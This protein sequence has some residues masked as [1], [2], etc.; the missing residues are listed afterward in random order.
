MAISENIPP[1]KQGCLKR[2]STPY[3]SREMVLDECKAWKAC[4]N[5][6]DTLGLSR[7]VANDQVLMDHT[8]YNRQIKLSRARARSSYQEE[9]KATSADWLFHRIPIERPDRFLP[10]PMM[11]TGKKKVRMDS[12]LVKEVIEFDRWIKTTMFIEMGGKMY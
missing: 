7:C 1:K 5:S 10:A 8:K 9:P 11:V 6:P 2:A 4:A 12:P 3:P